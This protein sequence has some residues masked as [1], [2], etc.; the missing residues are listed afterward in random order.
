MWID[1]LFVLESPQ[2]KFIPILLLSP[3]FPPLGTLRC[4]LDF[5]TP[6]SVSLCFFFYGFHIIFPCWFTMISLDTSFALLIPY[7]YLF[8]MLLNPAVLLENF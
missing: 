8:N 6:V 5:L 4:M 1:V 2:A 3:P 7:S